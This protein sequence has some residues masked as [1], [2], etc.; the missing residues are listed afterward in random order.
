MNI[1]YVG[2]NYK[3]AVEQ[4]VM[5]LLGM[6]SQQSDRIVSSLSISGQYITGSAKV[7]LGGAV[8]AASAKF[9]LKDISKTWDRVRAEQHVVKL[10]V[11]KAI[12]RATGKH[13]PWGS[14]SGMRPTKLARQFLD[15]EKTPAKVV[16]LLKDKF[17]IEP[18]RA[19]LVTQA[20]LRSV[21]AAKLFG[22]NDISLYIGI[23]FCPS[24]CS[25]C[26]FVSHD[27]GKSADMVEPYL[28]VLSDEIKHKGALAHKLG[29][30]V[31]TIYIGGGTP[32]TLSA[33]QLY[34]LMQQIESEFHISD[35]LEYTVEAG[36]PDTITLE[37]LHA[38]KSGGAER[39]SINPQSM[40]QHVLDLCGRPHSPE[41]VVRA[42][43][44]ARGV[45]FDSI[46]MDT[47]AGLQ[48]D[49]AAGFR[50]TLQEVLALSPENVTVHTLALKKGADMTEARHGYVDPVEVSSMLDFSMELL[51]N[52]GY[53]PYYLYRQKYM[54]ASLEN[55]G[56]TTPGY[57][58]L[59]NICIMEEFQSIL[60]LGAG[61]I[62]KLVDNSGR[63]IKRIANNKYP[64]EY[65]KSTKKILDDCIR[66]ES[67][68]RKGTASV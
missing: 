5:A 58:S 26:S 15:E 68:L 11:F 54:A 17:Y 4:S 13:Y 23:P 19:R 48:G 63:N 34:R 64:R 43:E 46:N 16:T 62:T 27:I 59:Y 42:Y 40:N 53:S 14:L 55:T 30:N 24:R 20:A 60:S 18:E 29:L 12:Q 67:I 47:I 33:E 39:I 65:I 44:L 51:Y 10:A 38:I 31:A 57:D 25:Y 52:N 32:T 6:E 56:W 8:G 49:T 7:E 50:H 9:A 28:Q 45:G 1:C 41:D 21:E 35:R 37:K 3:Y 2:H 61:G 36:R 22:P 66:I